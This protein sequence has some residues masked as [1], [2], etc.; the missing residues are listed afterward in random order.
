MAPS[1]VGCLLGKS[2]RQPYNGSWTA[3]EYAAQIIVFMDTFGRARTPAF[4]GYHYFQVFLTRRSKEAFAYLLHKEKEVPLSV[5][6]FLDD[7]YVKC[8]SLPTSMHMDNSPVNTGHKTQD[9]LRNRGVSCSTNVPH[10]PEQNM[11]ERLI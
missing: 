8:H 10:C 11:S 7:Y 1:C 2:K 9:L 4:G 5:A 6:R 3:S